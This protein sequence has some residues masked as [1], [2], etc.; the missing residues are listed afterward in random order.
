MSMNNLAASYTALGRRADALRLYEKTLALRKAKLGPDHP[1]TLLSMGNLASNL[2]DQDRGVEAVPVIDECLKRATGRSVDPRLVPFVMDLRL[3]HFGKAK[4]AAG[5]RQT[6]EMWEKLNRTDA[7][8]L[9]TA[10]CMWAVAAGIGA[11]TTG[12]DITPL[13]NDDTDRAMAR[14]RQALCAGYRDM[15]Q[16]HTD[17]DLAPLRNRADYAD[18]LWDIAD[19]PAGSPQN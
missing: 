19:M 8:S 9:Y 13:G 2:L 16:L 11:R 7:A 14:L 12:D 17:P 10:A 18:L 4:D 15:S 3:R 5:C 6:A 1:S